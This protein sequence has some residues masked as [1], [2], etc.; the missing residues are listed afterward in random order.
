VSGVF[1]LWPA[2]WPCALLALPAAAAL[3]RWRRARERRL[4]QQLG[5]GADRLVGAPA[6]ARWRWAADAVAALLLGVAA[7][8]PAMAGDVGEAGGDVALCVDVSWSMAARDQ[9]PSRLGRAQQAIAR[10]AASAADARAA[11]VGY[12]GDAFRV[13][14]LTADLAAVATLAAELAPGAHG[15]AGT[16]PGAAIDLAVALLQRGG[17]A[18]AVVVLS[19]GED[20]AGGALAA[21]ARARSAGFPVHTLGLGTAQGG[22]IVVDGGAGEAFL[23]D[24]AG[25][26]IVTHGEFD[27][28]AAWAA[29]GGGRFAAL[30]DVDGLRALHDGV[31]APAAREAAVRA[32]RLQPLPLWRWPLFAALALWMLAACAQE[33]RR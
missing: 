22:K 28:L 18:G 25:D 6:A 2:H 26:D 23:Q 29:A 17:R 3:W 4:Q 14:P 20:F 31:L 16:D 5:A 27:A 7:L 15:R 24:A 33:R 12:A 8:E 10:F 13:A 21:A 1:F 11:L 30:A 19:D 32:G 9:Q